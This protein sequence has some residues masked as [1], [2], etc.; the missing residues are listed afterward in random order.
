MVSLIWSSMVQHLLFGI[1]WSLSI[2]WFDFSTVATICSYVHC[3][4]CS[5]CLALNRK[6]SNHIVQSQS[7][8]VKRP[9]D[10]T[11]INIEFC[12]FHAKTI[13]Y[14]SEWIEW[15]VL[16]LLL[17]CFI[18]WDLYVVTAIKFKLVVQRSWDLI[19]WKRLHNLI[20]WNN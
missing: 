8:Q 4:K 1:W 10:R 14:N 17:S 16:E 18:D 2:N 20:N 12:D 11:K 15:G 6:Q 13:L 5:E 7:K 3:S 9:N 19:F